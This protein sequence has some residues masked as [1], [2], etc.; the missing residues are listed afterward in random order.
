MSNN[1]KEVLK[2]IS[3]IVNLRD[4]NHNIFDIFEKIIEN[5]DK[6][7][8]VE[9][10][11]KFKIKAKKN[12]FAN[13]ILLQCLVKY[14]GEKKQAY[15]EFYTEKFEDPEEYDDVYIEAYNLL[16]LCN[17]SKEEL[18]SLRRDAD[19]MFGSNGKYIKNWAEIL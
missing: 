7:F 3:K 16:K 18:E 19:L 14:F 9:V 1:K 12:Y 2:Q 4:I 8:L 11:K 15:E 6:N 17:R 5:N 10:Y 13:M